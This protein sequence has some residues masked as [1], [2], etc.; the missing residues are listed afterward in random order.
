MTDRDILL[1]KLTSLREHVAR[2]R[3]RRSVELA[4]FRASVDLQDSLEKLAA[5]V[6]RH[7]GEA[8]VGE[9]PA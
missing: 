4:A 9:T 5:A 1:R 7:L 6:A 8:N 2:L 3:R